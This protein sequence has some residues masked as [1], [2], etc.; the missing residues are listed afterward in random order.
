MSIMSLA[1]DHRP[2]GHEQEERADQDQDYGDYPFGRIRS[3][4]PHNRLSSLLSV[5]NLADYLIGVVYPA[6]KESEK[7]RCIIRPEACP[8]KTCN[9]QSENT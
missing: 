9:K 6:E 2:V 4:I 3:V 8:A 5:Y 1:G 7:P